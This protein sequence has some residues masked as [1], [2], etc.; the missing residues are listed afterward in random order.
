MKTEKVIIQSLQ[1]EIVYY[2]GQNKDENFMIIDMCKSKDYWI[3]AK[4]ESSCHVVIELP[5]YKL[6]KTDIRQI[7]KAGCLFCKQNTNKLKSQKKVEFIYTTIGNISKTNIAG[8]VTTKDTKT[9]I[10]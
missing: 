8:C 3:H 7:I 5:D 9:V 4:N 2:I 1:K 6:N 10:C